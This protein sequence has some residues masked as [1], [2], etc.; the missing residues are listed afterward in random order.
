[1]AKTKKD[2]ITIGADVTVTASI[3]CGNGYIH[4]IDK[5]MMPPAVA[6]AAPPAEEEAAPVA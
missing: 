1:V 4:V 5:V 3:K 2:V 6:V